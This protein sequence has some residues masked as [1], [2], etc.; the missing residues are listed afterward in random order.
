MKTETNKSLL[1]LNTFGLDQVAARFITINDE[2]E[3]ADALQIARDLELPVFILGGGSNILLTKDLDCLVLKINIKGIEL[4]REDDKYVWIKVGAGEIWHEFV[5][6]AIRNQWGGVENLSL[7][8]GTVGAS[9]MQNIGAYGAEI[10]DVFDHLE[11]VALADGTRTLFF[12]QDCRFGYRDS[13]FKQEAKGKFV[14]T[15]VIFRLN[16]F[17]N[18]NTSYG[19]I[20][21]TIQELGY[22][23]P[24]LK[25]ISDA[26]IFIR[27]Q[28]LPDPTVIGNAGSFFKNP[29][30]SVEKYERIKTAHPDVPGFPTTEG[31]KIPAAWLIERAGWKGKR[32]GPIGVH[33]MQPLVLVNYGGGKGVELLSLSKDITDDIKE[34]FDVQLET[35]VNIL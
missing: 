8:P 17:F 9:P 13:I 19:N 2:T 27:K 24:S 1:H 33:A 7:I 11:S 29:V 5:L 32:L 21:S 18:F 14:I 31:V 30:V 20:A 12:A 35:E 23:E 28:K 22:T 6:H 3:L 10:K 16:K 25:A 34:K 4:I 26:V 15:R